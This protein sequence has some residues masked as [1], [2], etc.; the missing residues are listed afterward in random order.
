MAPRSQATRTDENFVF[1]LHVSH[2]LALLQGH[3]D[4]FF[5]KRCGAV[6]A[7]GTLRMLKSQCDQDWRI[8]SESETQTRTRLDAER[9][10]ICRWEARIVTAAHFP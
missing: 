1:A 3:A 2:Q 9:A 10:N 6:N 5:C 8:S 7:G 4:V